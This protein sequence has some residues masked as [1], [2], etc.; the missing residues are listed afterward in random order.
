[1][2]SVARF[3][4]ERM[5]NVGAASQQSCWVKGWCVTHI[6]KV[7]KS[8]RVGCFPTPLKQPKIVLHLS[9]TSDSSQKQCAT[10]ILFVHARKWHVD[11]WPKWLNKYWNLVR[12]FEDSTG[13]DWRLDQKH[14]KID[15]NAYEGNWKGCSRNA[16]PVVT[17]RGSCLSVGSFERGRG[18]GVPRSGCN[19]LKQTSSF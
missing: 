8:C 19:H 10:H 16:Q 6:I 13:T 4:L 14:G 9:Y 15:V 11:G 7:S 5:S 17:D 3:L 1:M 12:I 18:R 2:A